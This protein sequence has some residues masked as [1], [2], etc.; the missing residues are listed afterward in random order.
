M[1]KDLYNAVT[2]II[3]KQE[4]KT[5]EERIEEL[6]KNARENKIRFYFASDSEDAM[7]ILKD[8]MTGKANIL[9]ELSNEILEVDS[10]SLFDN[11]SNL[12]IADPYL[13]GLKKSKE[14]R[15]RAFHELISEKP[16]DDASYEKFYKELK[17]FS[18][19]ADLGIT[20]TNYVISDF[21]SLVFIDSYGY[22][23]VLCTAPRTHV[24]IAS[25]DKI[26]VDF[27]ESMN[28]VFSYT[29]TLEPAFNSNVFVIN[30]PS[31]TGDIEKIVIY[32]AHG[33]R[34]LSLIVIDNGRKRLAEDIGI[35]QAVI[36]LLSDVVSIIY[37]QTTWLA[38]CLGVLTVNP[39]DLAIRIM[40][41][42]FDASVI[43]ALSKTLMDLLNRD[44]YIPRKEILIKSYEKLYELSLSKAESEE[45]IN[46]TY[47]NLKELVQ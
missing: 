8:I 1:S 12:L 32:G 11:K 35:N 44:A 2:K 21:S 7:S 4:K 3:E 30:N 16:I 29:K 40:K 26:L 17:E 27:F 42:N 6:E 45:K 23:G 18:F 31:R 33:P 36:R 5:F 9:M 13:Y 38:Y 39:L 43:G 10:F 47:L 20:T 14:F 37:P 34:E 15:T 19:N 28:Y 41:T 46:E 24:V 22:R 25:S